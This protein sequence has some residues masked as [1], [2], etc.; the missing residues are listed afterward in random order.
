MQLVQSSDAPAPPRRGPRVPWPILVGGLLL[1]YLPSLLP[2][3]LGRFGVELGWGPPGVLVW[4]W[5]AVG[6][7]ALYVWKVEGLGASSLRLV[8]PT[9][10]D[11]EWA[12][13]LGGAAVAWHWLS[14]QFLP[15]STAP[16][17][18][19]GGEALIALGPLLALAMVLTV[20]FTE[21]V[22]WRGYVVERLGA[23]IG[24][25]VAAVIGLTIFAAGHVPF[26]GTGWLI[27]A[28][29]GAVLLYVLLLWRRN[30]WACILCHLIGDIPVFV[31]ALLR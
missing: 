26:F 16:P 6:L 3:L 17:E 5:L 7:L 31:M 29:P 25:I 15:A 21:E 4:N 11:L 30:L 22:L 2:G 14:S 9:E 19:G 1:A 20:S 18:G 27:S 23:W 28:L 24:P 12:G 10:K 8:R 13:W